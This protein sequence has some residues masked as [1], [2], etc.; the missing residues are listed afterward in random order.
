MCEVS[1]RAQRESMLTFK[2]YLDTSPGEKKK[3]LDF[4]HKIVLPFL[5]SPTPCNKL[6]GNYGAITDLNALMLSYC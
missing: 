2:P 3:S 5:S 6:T 4:S 1:S